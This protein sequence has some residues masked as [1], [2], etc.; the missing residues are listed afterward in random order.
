MSLGGRRLSAE[1]FSYRYFVARTITS[2][3]VQSAMAFPKNEPIWVLGSETLY[4]RTHK[5]ST[6]AE[7]MLNECFQRKPCLPERF[8]FIATLQCICRTPRFS[9]AVAS[10]DSPARIGVLDGA[11]RGSRT[12]TRKIPTGF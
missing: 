10:W 8:S 5:A 3:P 4:R 6:A 12:H 11:G 1:P 9:F 2:N 7:V